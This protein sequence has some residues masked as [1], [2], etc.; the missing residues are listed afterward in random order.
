MWALSNAELNQIHMA[1]LRRR[2]FQCMQ[3]QMIKEGNVMSAELKSW[4]QDVNP[5]N[6]YHYLEKENIFSSNSYLLL[7]STYQKYTVYHLP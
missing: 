5:H 3:V 4:T 2:V 7:L 6:I 1:Q